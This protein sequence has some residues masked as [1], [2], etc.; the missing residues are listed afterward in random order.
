[1]RAPKALIDYNRTSGGMTAGGF[2]DAGSDDDH[3][4]LIK[5]PARGEH[6]ETCAVEELYARLARECRIEM[7]ETRFFALGRGLTAF[8]TR[9]FDRTGLLRVPVHTLAGA[10]HV[11]F[12]ISSV[13]LVDFLRF[14]RLIT[15]DAREVLRAFER[16]VF[17]LLF[18]N[19]DDH[20]KNFSYR[21]GPNDRWKLSPAYDL[22]YNDGPG[23]HHQMGYDGHTLA[24]TRADALSA[25][26]KG[27]VAPA[28]AVETIDRLSTVADRLPHLVEDLPIRKTSVT[29]LVKVTAAERKRLAS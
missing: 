2:S 27:G 24:P 1:M 5:F 28:A 13:D 16:C 18:R 7:P 10:L 8:G 14:T 20:A 11:D 9:R 15:G 29:N 6:P 17:N 23:G 25:A 22:N 4:W 19:R 3:A 21:L 12:R 26:R